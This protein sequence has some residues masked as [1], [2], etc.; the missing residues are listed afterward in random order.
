M[1][2]KISS[3]AA[4][5]QAL[6]NS[7]KETIKDDTEVIV[8]QVPHVAPWLPGYQNLAVEG[9]V[10]ASGVTRCGFSYSIVVRGGGECMGS[11]N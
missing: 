7:P 5:R 6:V 3:G 8:Y 1:C 2:C 10:R 4:G 9:R 11:L